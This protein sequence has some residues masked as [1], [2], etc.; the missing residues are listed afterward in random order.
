MI[1]ILAITAVCASLAPFAR[2]QGVLEQV[3]QGLDNAGRNIRRSVENGVARGQ[4]TAQENE[5][6]A[7][8]SER[9]K[10]DKRLSKSTIRLAVSADRS[11]V[12]SGSVIS[13]SAKATAVEIT[14]NT[15]GVT[16]VV[17]EIAVVKEVRVIK[18]KVEPKRVVVEEVREEVITKP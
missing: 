6:L 16:S 8:V 13:E 5:V 11:I 2:A 15:V 4:I 17:D 9:I 14:E 1:R 18:P 10:W 3:G 7:R 12:L